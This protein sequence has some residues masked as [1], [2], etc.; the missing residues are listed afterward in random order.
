MLDY[1]IRIFYQSQNC[2]A[3]YALQIF[4]SEFNCPVWLSAGTGNLVKRI[5]DPNPKTVSETTVSRFDLTRFDSTIEWCHLAMGY[6]KKAGRW[7]VMSLLPRVDPNLDSKLWGW[8]HPCLTNSNTNKYNFN[9]FKNCYFSFYKV[10]LWNRDFNLLNMH[11]YAP[12][13]TKVN[14]VW[15][16]TI[17]IYQPEAGIKMYSFYF[18]HRFH[19]LKIRA[20]S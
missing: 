17:T 18:C 5:L 9:K 6:K 16:R 7:K 12:A 15:N 14:A 19:P 4:K 11:R 13:N 8:H 10:K 3:Q 2:F 20:K 1:T